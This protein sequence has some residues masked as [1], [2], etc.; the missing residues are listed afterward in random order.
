MS[1]QTTYT[2]DQVRFFNGALVD[3]N[4]NEIV[5][6]AVEEGEGIPF[7]RVVARGTNPENQVLLPAADSF[8]GIAIRDIAQE[9]ET[10]G[11]DAQYDF[12]DV[13]SILRTGYIALTCPSGCVPGDV[14]HYEDDIPLASN[15]GRVDTGVAGADQT[16]I[17]HAEWQ[18]TTAAGEIAILRLGIIPA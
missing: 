14:A 17:L 1:A 5:S 4:E 2:I 15:P 13:V 8:Y 11:A 6:A 9:P 10:I 16:D 18:T 3:L 12:E 7:G